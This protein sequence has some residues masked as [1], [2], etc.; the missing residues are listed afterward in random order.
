MFTPTS[1]QQPLVAC[2]SQRQPANHSVPKLQ[3]VYACMKHVWYMQQYTVPVHKTGCNTVKLT[4]YT[5]WSIMLTPR[6]NT[7]LYNG[8][9]NR[10]PSVYAV[11]LTSDFVNKHLGLRCRGCRV[12]KHVPNEPRIRDVW[13]YREIPVCIPVIPLSLGHVQGQKVE[14]KLA[15]AGHIVAAFRTACLS[16]SLYDSNMHII[17]YLIG[18][19]MLNSVQ[20][21]YGSGKGKKTQFSTWHKITKCRQTKES[22]KKDKEFWLQAHE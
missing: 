13:R 17:V 5:G 21:S 22:A 19:Q 12:G 20:L 11:L 4:V 18:W 1:Q 16:V 10:S 14:G 9:Y 15:G 6:C 2:G 7:E 8:L 3:L